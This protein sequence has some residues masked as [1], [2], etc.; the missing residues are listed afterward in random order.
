MN[1]GG[2]SLGIFGC[3]DD[4]EYLE[5]LPGYGW[6]YIP[7]NMRRKQAPDIP[8]LSEVEVMRHFFRLSQESTCVDSGFNAEGTCTMKYNP[9]VNEVLAG[10]SKVA[11][12][13]P[14]QDGE[15]V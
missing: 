4:P 8:E 5:Q 11:E 1:F 10:S 9:K 13:H 7:K 15:S 6:S 14:L 3:R 2:N 12:L